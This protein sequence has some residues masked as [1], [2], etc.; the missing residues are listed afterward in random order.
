MGDGIGDLL[1]D[2][3]AGGLERIEAGDV[4]D[5]AVLLHEVRHDGV[6][7]LGEQRDR[8]NKTVAEKIDDAAQRAGEDGGDHP[9]GL[10]DRINN[11][12]AKLTDDLEELKEQQLEAFGA[13]EIDDDGADRDGR[14][15][16]EVINRVAGLVEL[17]DGLGRHDLAG[18]AGLLGDLGQPLL[19]QLAEGGHQL[20][21]NFFAENGADS[22]VGLVLVGRVG[23]GFGDGLVL[24][25]QREADEVLGFEPELRQGLR[26]LFVAIGR[27]E[28]GGLGLLERLGELLLAD[29]VALVLGLERLQGLDVDAEIGGG[30]GE[31]AGQINRAL[32]QGDEGAHRDADP[33]LGVVVDEAVEV[34]PQ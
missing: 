30:V 34:L 2:G 6:E 13:T 33:E 21:P 11:A 12:R 20:R 14:L 28:D 9:A 5:E 31:V 8:I 17:G 19:G 23:G 32:G 10:V 1:G 27:G 29:T 24:L 3:L 18:L 22:R 7:L 26:G 15:F 4:D 25:I 16:L